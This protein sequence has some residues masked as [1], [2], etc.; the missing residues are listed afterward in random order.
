MKTN[1][2]STPSKKPEKSAGRVFD[3]R[4]P[5]KAPASPTSRPVIVGHKPLVQDSVAS[6]SGLGAPSEKRQLLSKPKQRIQINPDAVN[7]TSEDND[8]PS[9]SSP[10]GPRP[11]EVVDQEQPAQPS[12]A[13]AG[14][15]RPPIGE[16]GQAP[17][18][19]EA[20]AKTAMDAT[21]QIRVRTPASRRIE[22][23][24]VV[25]PK[26]EEPEV[27]PGAPAMLT[28]DSIEEPEP[29]PKPQPE[30]KPEPA[31]VPEPEPAQ[32]EE[33]APAAE[34]EPQPEPEQP[35]PVA[36]PEP[37]SQ[38]EPKQEP[39]PAVVLAPP[40]E[41]ESKPE[42]V[43]PPAAQPE[44]SK[45]QSGPQ[46]TG[47]DLVIGEGDTQSE[48]TAAPEPEYTTGHPIVVSHHGGTSAW[49]VVLLLLVIVLLAAIAVDILIDGGVL[50]WPVPHTN[51][52]QS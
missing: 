5:G 9:G 26:P 7:H 28:A 20:L 29:L 52:F 12:Q 24:T 22:P 6:V 33:P 35:Q 8:Q 49:K 10:D 44:P 15:A 46:E 3:V 43:A 4:R 34:S 11:G 19:E 50:N 23:L 31:A 18:T 48:E 21:T 36:E 41:P 16:A 42:P 2:K 17:E 37:E 1:D 47:T 38:P 25:E 14:Q 45:E 13:E 27:K 40:P 51:F 39:K 30:P 32:P